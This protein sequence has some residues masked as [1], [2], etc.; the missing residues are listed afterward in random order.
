MLWVK[1]EQP[2]SWRS[3][4]WKSSYIYIGSYDAIESQQGKETYRDGAGVYYVLAAA[5]L[6][7]FLA[8]S[9]SSVLI[10]SRWYIG[11]WRLCQLGCLWSP[12]D[13]G[14]L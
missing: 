12:W 4:T 7:H 10:L 3:G 2:W 14:Y 1:V 13:F 5:P 8:V 11:I 6:L 9:M